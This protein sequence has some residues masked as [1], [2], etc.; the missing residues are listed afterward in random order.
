L[1]LFAESFLH[2]L[3]S[4]R[5]HHY[6]RR[7]PLWSF[8]VRPLAFDKESDAIFCGSRRIAKMSDIR[9]VGQ[10]DHMYFDL[11]WGEGIVICFKAIG[12][13]LCIRTVSMPAELPKA[14]LLGQFLGVRTL[15]DKNRLLWEPEGQAEIQGGTA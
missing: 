12:T 5:L 11:D 4:F 10:S 8:L 15:D 14:A 1:L 9:E 3:S 6:P 7:G 13:E 2:K